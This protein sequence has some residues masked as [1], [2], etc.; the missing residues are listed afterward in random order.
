MLLA[1]DAVWYA[2]HTFELSTQHQLPLLRQAKAH[3]TSLRSKMG[4]QDFFKCWQEVSDA[5][6]LSQLG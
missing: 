4:T 1:P 6:V 5:E 3:L 2:A